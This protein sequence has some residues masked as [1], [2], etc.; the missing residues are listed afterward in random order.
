MGILVR[1][2]TIASPAL[3]PWRRRFFIAVAVLS[4]APLGL[5][6]SQYTLDQLLQA[7]KSGKPTQAELVKQV[8]ENGVPFTLDLETL[9]K[10]VQAGATQALIQ[11]IEEPRN[12]PAA[13]AKPAASAE[14]GV[15]VFSGEA[16][17]GEEGPVT[18][19]HIL[20]V[21]QNGGDQALL[22]G[23]VAQYG[24]AFPYTPTLGREFQDAGANPTLLS[25]IAT[26]TVGTAVLPDGF[27]VLPVA[28]AKDFTGQE[29]AGRF[30]LR[31]YVDG[32]VEVRIQGSRV[33]FKTLQA[34]PVR[35]AGTET[36]GS[37]PLR[38]LKKLDIVKRDGRGGFVLLQKPSLEN[39][40]QTIL[41]I[42]DPKGGEDRYHLRIDWQAE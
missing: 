36:T 14:S 5:P 37:F 31:L 42:Y 3:L 22:A 23:L 9:D 2:L 35:D 12:R 29:R 18:R 40:F 20:V 33:I 30:D 21:L 1:I 17:T 34:Q 15:A 6:Q 16:T 19:E 7:L 41:R 10:L 39:E 24:I 26:A 25:M 4:F 38:P 11:A 32:A 28:K 13:A 27:S 8:T